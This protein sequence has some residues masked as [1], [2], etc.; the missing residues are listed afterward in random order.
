MASE[1]FK[2]CENDDV[3]IERNPFKSKKK[4]KNK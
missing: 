1:V 3:A 4:K 2:L